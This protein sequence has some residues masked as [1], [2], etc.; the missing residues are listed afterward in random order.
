MG[1]GGDV[2]DEGSTDVKE[3]S[4][5]VDDWVGKDDV[6]NSEVER[7]GFSVVRIED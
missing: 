6:G 3:S 5:E 7:D 4:P 2:D 1:T